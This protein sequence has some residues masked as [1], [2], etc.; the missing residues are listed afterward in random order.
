M[1]IKGFSPFDKTRSPWEVDPI[2]C[3][4]MAD[5][6]SFLFDDLTNP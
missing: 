6:N 3:D 2:S 4:Q 5:V 1:M